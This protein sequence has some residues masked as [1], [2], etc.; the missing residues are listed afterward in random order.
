M[1]DRKRSLIK[2]ICNKG[3]RIIHECISNIGAFYNYIAEK[4]ISRKKEKGH[5]IKVGFICQYIPAWN[6]IEPVYKLLK[7]DDRFDAYLL[8][9]QSGIKAGKLISPSCKENDTYEYFISHGYPEAINTY[10]EK[11][12]WL[13]L[14]EYDL[15]YIFFPRPYNSFM[16]KPYWS[17]YVSKY[18]KICCIMYGAT[19][20]LDTYEVALNRDFFNNV[21]YYFA[22]SQEALEIC[23]Q[24]FPIAHKCKKLNTIFV[25]MTALNEMVYSKKGLSPSWKFSNNNYRV[26]WT[27]RWTTDKKLGGSNFFTYKEAILQFAA[28]NPHIDFLIRPHPLMFEHFEET[29]EFTKKER[30]DYMYKIN[31]LPNVQIDTHEEYSATFWESDLLISDVSGIIAE[32]FATGKPIIFCATNYSLRSSRFF[33]ELLTGCYTVLSEEELFENIR[34]L[35]K[36]NDVLKKKRKLLSEKMLHD[37]IN[38]CNAVRDIMLRSI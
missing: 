11:N 38:S 8:C 1:I 10:V 29:G 22:E 28:S 35:E 31:K 21:T 4:N 25:G 18:T 33:E 37:S 36:K 6:K 27:P 7:T 2:R 14:K 26:L 30:D 15:D 34:N 23:R 17:R 20:D 19:M 12:S 3:W 13:D 32:Y 5:V 9:V 24:K 16:P